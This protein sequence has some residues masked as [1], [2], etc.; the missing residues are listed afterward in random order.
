MRWKQVWQQDKVLQN[1]LRSTA[2]ANGIR[3]TTDG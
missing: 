1:R 3:D 2:R